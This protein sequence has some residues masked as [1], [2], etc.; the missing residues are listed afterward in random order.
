MVVLDKVGEGTE[1]GGFDS[2]ENDALL[3]LEV[4]DNSIDDGDTDFELKWV[5]GEEGR[6]A[7][8]EEEGGTRP[9]RDNEESKVGPLCSSKS[10]GGAFKFFGVS[11]F[12][13]TA[14]KNFTNFRT[15]DFLWIHAGGVVVVVDSV[16]SFEFVFV[17]VLLVLLVRGM[18][19]IVVGEESCFRSFSM[20]VRACKVI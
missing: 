6:V 18:M 9:L 15:F 19:G 5:E 14:E 4:E 11:F 20:A 12:G 1:G 16:G 13:S 2:E 17:F 10:D 3:G 8:M 7:E